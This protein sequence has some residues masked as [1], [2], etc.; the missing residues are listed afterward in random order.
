MASLY[1]RA[2]PSQR[3]ILRV[4]KGA[5]KNAADAHPQYRVSD[6]F[7]RSVA[8]R[9]AGTLTAQWPD[10]LAARM[11]SERATSKPVKAGPAKAHC[12]KPTQGE[13]LT[14]ARRSPFKLLYTRLGAMAGSARKA[15]HDARAA[16]LADALRVVASVHAELA[17]KRD[18]CG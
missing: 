11:P 15:G 2:T 6:R 1:N 8:K 14:I 17:V 9:A 12:L 5:V 4:I 16:A 10:V 13:R 3:R 7:A 18:N